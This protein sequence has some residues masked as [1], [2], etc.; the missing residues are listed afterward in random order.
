MRRRERPIAAETIPEIVEWA[1]AKRKKKKVKNKG[2]ISKGEITT[3]KRKTKTGGT[4]GYYPSGRGHSFVPRNFS[5]TNKTLKKS[6]VEGTIPSW[7]AMARRLMKSKKA[8][9][10]LIA[11]WKKRLEEWEAKNG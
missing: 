3:Q 4:Y 9:S 2:K 7:V 6:D 11:Y 8:N 1:E 10:K 5:N